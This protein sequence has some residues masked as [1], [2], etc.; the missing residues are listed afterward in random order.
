MKTSLQVLRCQLLSVLAF[1]ALSVG[2]V[3]SAQEL[4]LSHTSQDSVSMSAAH[5]SP[6]AAPKPPLLD[7]RE[8]DGSSSGAWSSKEGTQPANTI[9]PGVIFQPLALLNTTQT[10]SLAHDDPPIHS[11]KTVSPNTV[12]TESHVNQPLEPS[13]DFVNQGQMHN[14]VWVPQVRNPFTVSTNQASI[15]PKSPS[16][17]VPNIDVEPTAR[18]APGP[19]AVMSS[20]GSNRGDTLIA[21]NVDHQ[22]LSVEEHTNPSWQYVS[23][24]HRSSLTSLSSSSMDADPALGQLREHAWGASVRTARHTI[25]QREVPA[26]N[27]NPTTELVTVK[28]PPENLTSTAFSPAL[29][30][31]PSLNTQNPTIIPINHTAP[32]ETTTEEGNGQ[33]VQDNSTDST[34][35]GPWFG[36]VTAYVGLL[37]NSSSVE[38][39][40]AQGNSSEPLST[41]SRKYQNRQ[42]PATTQDPWMPGNSSDPT[43]NSPQSRLTICFSRMDIVWIVLAISVPVSSCS[44]LLTVCCMRRKKKSSN[45][46]NNLSYWNNAITMDYFSRHAVELPREIHTLESEEHDTCLP[47]NGDYSGSSV[48]LVNPFCQETLFINRDK[49]SAI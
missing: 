8:D 21:H 27:E 29:P 7:L 11:T 41:D 23:D 18:Q 10:S 20:P 16:T 12:S 25:T 38:E 40:A 46:E 2:L 31:G 30:T 44:V 43:A 32:N 42:V 15:S 36:N 39:A 3:S 13:S 24:L 47:P 26:V 45:Q 22:K 17:A 19:L 48:V 5:R 4:Y 28:S 49:A 14:L 37:S 35:L 33:V 1:L 6:M 9:L 34:P